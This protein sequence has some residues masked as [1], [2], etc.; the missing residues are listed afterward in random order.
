MKLERILLP[1]DKSD[2]SIKA[3]QYALSYAEQFGSTIHLLHCHKP[4]FCFNGEK[5]FNKV[6]ARIYSK[7]ETCIEVYRKLCEERNVP[8][9]EI[10]L[11]PPASKAI[12]DTAKEMKADII[13]MGSS[14]KSDFKGLLEGSVT[15]KVIHMAECPVLVINH[16]VSATEESEMAKVS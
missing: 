10:I 13:I 16:H 8:H 15:H 12:I 6:K 1:V 7:A 2:C 14:G 9:E 4:V 5:E 3:T 11:E